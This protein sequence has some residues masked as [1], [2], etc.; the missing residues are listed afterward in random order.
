MNPKPHHPPQPQPAIYRF[1]R[2]FVLDILALML[3]LG[4]GLAFALI[5]RPENTRPWR[6][7]ITNWPGFDYLY[8]A[9][10]K[11][12]FKAHGL[13]IE[14]VPINSII[15]MRTAFERGLIDGYTSA[16]LDV[17]ESMQES[18]TPARIVLV[19]DYSKGAD[20]MLATPSITTVNDLS[21][22]KMGIELSSAVSRYIL[23]RALEGTNVRPNDIRL[24][25]GSQSVLTYQ[26]IRGDLDA[27]ITYHPFASQILEKRDMHI[28]FDTHAISEEIIDVVAVSPA[29]VEAEPELSRRLQLAWQ[30]AIDYANSH[31]EETR[32]LF[33]R[34][35]GITLQQYQEMN[36]DITL[37][38]RA[39]NQRMTR[40]GTVARAIHKA[41]V[42]LNPQKPLSEATISNTV[43]VW[44]QQEGQR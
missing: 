30:S 2:Q 22:T 15:D 26:A 16:V 7:A 31:P 33:A 36:N 13:D 20:M 18:G 39:A 19:T 17:T 38:D 29:M 32:D 10:Q 9:K 23:G 25:P 24:I 42:T 11:G 3:V 4:G 43:D 35:Y 8:L 41:A 28:L 12:F 44:Y 5:Q 21:N 37:V 34:R 40:D 1:N 14:L 6:I 27:I